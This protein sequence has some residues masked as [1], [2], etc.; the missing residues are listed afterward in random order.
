MAIPQRLASAG[1]D[2]RT[3]AGAGISDQDVERPL[4]AVVSFLLGD[5]APVPVPVPV[6][7]DEDLFVSP[8]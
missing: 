3:T 4:L 7:P 5:D 1:R 6:P 2:S 8:R